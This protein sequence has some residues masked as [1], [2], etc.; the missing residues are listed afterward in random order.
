[1]YE[2]PISCEL[3]MG[4]ESF[5]FISADFFI[6]QHASAHAPALHYYIPLPNPV[7]ND[8]NNILS[9]HFTNGSWTILPNIH[10]ASLIT[11]GTKFTILL[12]H[13]LYHSSTIPR[14]G[15]PRAY[16]ISMPQRYGTVPHTSPSSSYTRGLPCSKDNGGHPNGARRH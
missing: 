14:R 10:I 4:D 3:P 16:H 7:N 15:N 5:P 13:S 12:D 11:H 1:M 9:I 6:T 8:D 2:Y